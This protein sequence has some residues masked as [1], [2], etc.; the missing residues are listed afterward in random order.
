MSRKDEIFFSS[1]TPKYKFLTTFYHCNIRINGRN[2]KS[3]EHY[4]QSRKTRN[5]KLQTWIIN[6][7]T[8]SYAFKAGRSLKDEDKIKEWKGVRK[9]MMKVA[10]FAKFSQNRS[11]RLRLLSTGDAKLHE[12]NR[13]DLLWGAYGDDMLGKLLVEIRQSIKQQVR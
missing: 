8:A 1:K 9:E 2:Y 4:Y 3:V 11:L 5:H 10:L 13:R 6:A 12:D 7:P